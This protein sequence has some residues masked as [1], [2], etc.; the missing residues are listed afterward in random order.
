M[1][2]KQDL[3]GTGQPV[4]RVLACIIDVVCRQLSH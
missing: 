3:E 4:R 1:N 2:T